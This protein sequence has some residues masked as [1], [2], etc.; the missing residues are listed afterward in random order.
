[1]YSVRKNTTRHGNTVFNILLFNLVVTAVLIWQFGINYLVIFCSSIIIHLIIETPLTLSGLRKSV[2]YLYGRKMPRVVDLFLRALVEGPGLC[3][4]AF[5]VADQFF[6]GKILTGVAGAALM[7]G[8]GALYMGLSDRR[9]LR[10]IP[11]GEEPLVSRR[12]MTQPGLIMFLALVNTGSLA[13]L[14]LMPAPYR[15]HAFTYLMAYSGLVMLF[16]F[17]NYN[18]GVRMVEFYDHERGEFTRPGPIF[19]AAALAYDSI[20]EMGLMVSPAYWVMFYLGVF[21]FTTIA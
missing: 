5:F 12:A 15:T 18:L 14:F 9:D 20:Y 4:P 2:V 11:P 3:V 7:V 17:I 10:L 19:Q 16:Y 6:A 1:M 8:F 13:A 21:H